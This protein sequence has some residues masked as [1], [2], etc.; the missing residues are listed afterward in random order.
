M[1]SLLNLIDTIKDKKCIEITDI[2]TSA[3]IIA[4]KEVYLAQ[5]Q[6]LI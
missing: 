6:G 5:I 3:G 4:N 1:Q 2:K